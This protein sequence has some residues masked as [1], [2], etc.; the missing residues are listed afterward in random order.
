MYL[1]LVH[2]YKSFLITMNIQTLCGLMA[3]KIHKVSE[4]IGA[5]RFG[6]LNK[7]T[8]RSAPNLRVCNLVSEEICGWWGAHCNRVRWTSMWWYDCPC[9]M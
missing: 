9:K 7:C 4:E 8:E 6:I 3:Q 1:S 5:V 2:L